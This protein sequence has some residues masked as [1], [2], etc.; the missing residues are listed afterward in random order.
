METEDKTQLIYSFPRAKGEEIHIAVRKYKG[1][2]YVDLRIWFQGKNEKTFYPTK[3][4]FALFLDQI[5][6]L[7][8]G[9]ERLS[10]ATEKLR[11]APDEIEV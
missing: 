8:K 11:P 2:Q 1:K 5:P 3:K 10:K 4:G 6:E 7:K 9:V